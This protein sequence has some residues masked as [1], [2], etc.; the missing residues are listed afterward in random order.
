MME[1]GL[2]LKGVGSFYEVLTDSGDTVTCKARGTFRRE[3][4]TPTVGD[5]VGIER[6]E[7]GY[8][9]LA[10]I[11]PR[12]NVLI[13]PAVA[14]VDQLMI[15]VSASVPSPDWMLLDR[16]IIASNCLGIEPIPVLNKVDTA[17]G[18]VRETFRND[19]RAFRTL[20]VSAETG[21]GIPDLNALLKDKVTCFAGQSAV[22]KSSILNR[23]LPDLHLETGG[24]SRK[25]ERGR[26]TTRHA[27]LWP[28]LGGAVLDTPGFSLFETECLEQAQ[29][30]AC[31]PEFKNAAPCRFAGCMH[32]TEPECGVKPL[33]ETGELSRS[34]YER[35][36]EI[37]K[38]Y[39]TRRKHRYD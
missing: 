35:Y 23:L 5:R 4:L 28:Y 36:V 38:E 19:Y 10:S 6:Q 16:L 8:A 26:H 27:E 12:R 21:E 30:D 18:H 11:L 20:A 1:Y 13:R 24:L 3:G 22:G 17:S 33:L 15:V 32:V 2:L 37:A 29:L 39:Q 31:Y 34:R 14:N 25:T 9:Q 7:Q